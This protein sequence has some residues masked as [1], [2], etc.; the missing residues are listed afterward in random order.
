MKLRLSALVSTRHEYRILALMLIL[1]HLALWG[2][3]SGPMSRSLM[4]AHLGLFIIWQPLWSRELRLRWG[5][6]VVFVLAA[7]AVTVWLDSWILT[8]WLLLLIGIVGGKVTVGRIDRFAYLATLLFLFTDLLIAAVPMTFRLGPAASE[9]FTVFGHGLLILP[10]SLF[11]VSAGSPGLQQSRVD[12]L[13]GLMISMLAAILALGALINTLYTGTPYVTVLFQAVIA[14]AIFLFTI[15]WLWSPLAGF[16]GLGQLWQRY[17]LNIG[18]PFEQW[19]GRLAGSAEAQATPQQFLQSAMQQLVALPWVTG[20]EWQ[21]GEHTG[22][23]GFQTTHRFR[24]RVADLDCTVYAEREAGA[25]LLLHGKLLV[26][27]IAHFYRAKRR[28][29]QLSQSAQLRA[30]YETGA[31]V[32]HDIKNL[33]QSLHTMTVAV[34]R[35]GNDSEA[36]ALLKRQL[37]HVT[38]RLQLALDKLQAPAQLTLT[39]CALSDWWSTLKQRKASEGI[40]F[41]EELGTDPQVPLDLFDSV[42]ENL[43]D[44]ARIKRQ[45]E[46]EL[47][48]EVNLIASGTDLRIRVCDDGSPVDEVVARDLLKGPVSSRHG[49]GIGLFQAAR[50]AEQL[51]YRLWLDESKPGHV[52]FELT[53]VGESARPPHPRRR[54]TDRLSPIETSSTPE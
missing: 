21:T 8:F 5:S 34:E 46:P 20:A 47:K 17:L 31:R 41:S 24:V 33:L 1:L 53:R 48:I 15:G 43:L 12:F 22:R 6:A 40:R 37:P 7:L 50:Q 29:V 54:S 28:E 25:G 18:T 32:T 52:C 35:G 14:V 13:Y 39:E 26:H 44:N 51:G 4:L 19:L 30:I 10:V 36:Q 42:I 3:L 2:D 9:S 27:L 11:V 49:L 16:S 23:E 45:L 38:Q